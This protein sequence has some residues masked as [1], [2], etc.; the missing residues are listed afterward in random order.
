M[1]SRAPLLRFR[2]RPIRV[3]AVFGALL[4]GPALSGMHPAVAQNVVDDAAQDVVRKQDA[5][6]YCGDEGVWL[7]ILGGGGQD[8]DD[9]ETPASYAVF[10]DNAARLIV[11][12]ASGASS[13]FDRSGGRMT[14]VDAIVLSH[15]GP[16]RAI[17]LPAFLLGA[18]LAERNRLLPIIGPTGA[19]TPRR[20]LSTTELVA[21]LVGPDGAFPSLSSTLPPNAVGRFRASPRDVPATGSRRWSDFASAHLE[22]EALPVTHGDIPALAWAVEL[23]G[24]RIVFAADSAPQRGALA[25]FAADA[26]ALVIHHS[27]PDNARGTLTGFHMTPTQIGQLAAQA[28][29]RMVILGH[30]ANRTRGR[31]TVSTQ[32]IEAHYQGSLIF[33]NDL[34][35]WGL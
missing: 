35:C 33:A 9:G 28:K 14:D 11:D 17:D 19:N 2:T 16:E 6:P 4:L 25:A 21:R 12:P 10:L 29:V 32:A 34:E 24:K 1:K 20:H 30:R 31:E 3:L 8:L 27:I 22:L 5:T 13:L 7:Q 23:G 18:Q 26:D 15:N